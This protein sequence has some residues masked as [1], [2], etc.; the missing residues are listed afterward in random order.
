MKDKGIYVFYMMDEFT[1]YM[2]G[3]IIRSKVPKQIINISN[4]AWIENGAGSP[5]KGIFSDRGGEFRNKHM[6]EFSQNMGLR[7]Y[8]TA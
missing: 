5:S 7:L 4:A 3:R 2:K 6:V 1:K 8:S